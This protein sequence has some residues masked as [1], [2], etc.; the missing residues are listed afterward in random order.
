MTHDDA[1][2]VMRRER[3]RQFDPR[4]LDVFIEIAPLF[5]EIHSRFADAQ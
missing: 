1:V 3:G 4:L 5:G 2:A